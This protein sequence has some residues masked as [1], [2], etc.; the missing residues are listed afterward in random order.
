MATDSASGVP[1]IDL[2]APLSTDQ[3]VIRRIDRLLDQDSRRQRS[4]WLFFLSGD[5]LQLPAVVPIDDMP[6]RPDALP[7]DT[8][9]RAPAHHRRRRLTAAG[10]CA[11]TGVRM[12][13]LPFTP[14]RVLAAL[15]GGA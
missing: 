13:T 2:A 1:G 7:G 6:E 10:A 3:D 12:R 8:G 15:A 9:R 14:A 4:L 11:A 5:G